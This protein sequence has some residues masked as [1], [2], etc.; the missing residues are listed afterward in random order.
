MPTKIEQ[1][2]NEMHTVMLGVP[3]TEEKGLAGDLKELVIQVKG[4]NGSVKK[5]TSWRELC[6]WAVPV[7]V[8]IIVALTTYIAVRVV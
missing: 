2:V 7:V 8:A 3:G 6:Q 5:N 4:I 1:K